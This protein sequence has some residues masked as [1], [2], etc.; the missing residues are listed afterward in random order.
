MAEARSLG[1]PRLAPAVGGLDRRSLL[2]LSAAQALGSAGVSMIVLV[3]GIVGS[4]L[5]PSPAWSTLP[6]AAMVVGL[7]ASS[8]PAA[9]LMKRIGRRPG[10][11]F[12]AVLATLASCLGAWAMARGSFALLCAATALIGA[13]GAFVSQYRFAAAESADSAQAAKAVSLVL[14]GGVMAGLLGP[15]LGRLG[16]DW[17]G[18]APFAG[19]FLLAACLYAGAGLLLSLLRVPGPARRPAGGPRQQ[20]EAPEPAAAR[21][22]AV[23]LRQPQALAALLAGIVAYAVMTFTM[24]AA[25]V[26]MNVLD[27]HPLNQAGFVIQSHIVAMY[28][29]S[30]F[31]GFLMARLGLVPSMLIGVLLLAG[32]TGV[33]L[34]GS[35][36]AVYW[37]A[38]VLLGLGWNF[39]FVGATTLLTRSY[40]PAERFQ[41]QGA[42]DFL[43][44]GFQAA[45][46]LLSGAALFRL[47]WRTLNLLNLPVLALV[48]VFLLGLQ[49]SP[50]LRPARAG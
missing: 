30:F 19:S 44:F 17:F 39:L 7:A 43:V 48:L 41:V 20:P 16:K 49:L 15:A 45:S 35:Q 27:H 42:N 40:R 12:G 38:L 26:S 18:A 31:T 47:G 24:T 8:G 50:R 6:V 21:P 32:S 46:S 13:N 14:A 11:L 33:S 22:L 2:L 3:G 25:P 9:L 5:A 10:F 34:L 23:I 37:A 28:A 29:P 1:A 4:R 36:L